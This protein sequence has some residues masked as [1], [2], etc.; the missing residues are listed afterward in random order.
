MP[1][2]A[3]SRPAMASRIR[4]AT[5]RS[6]APRARSGPRPGFLLRRLHALKDINLE[7]PDKAVTAIIGPSGCGKS[8][9]LRIFNRIYA[10]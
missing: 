9:L 7:I 2:I 5:V 8:T 4:A 10:V 3:R 6:D 1:M